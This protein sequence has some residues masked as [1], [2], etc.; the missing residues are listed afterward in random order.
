M[1]DHYVIGITGGSGS[2]KTSFT[3]RLVENLRPHVSVLTLDNYYH[4][5]HLQPLD[6]NGKPNF[7]EPHSLDLAKFQ[8]DFQRLL[9]NETVTLDEY[10][11]N[12][13]SLVPKQIV[14]KPAKLLILEGLYV[15]HLP[16]LA[17][18]IDLKVFIELNDE[19][20]V[21]R[22]LRRDAEERGYNRD[23]VLYSQT[24]HVSPAYTS[25]IEKHKH[26]ADLVIPNYPNFEK[27]LEVLTGFLKSTVK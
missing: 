26:D 13:P 12:N 22:R 24:H 18:R 19:E 1:S 4:P 9:A 6:A 20:K 17:S 7:D 25:Y 5:I 8:N 21:A 23:D 15:F 11:F 10:T 16:E 2:G 27:G 3:V 14:V